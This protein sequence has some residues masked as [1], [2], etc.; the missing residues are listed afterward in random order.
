MDTLV[1]RLK[2]KKKQFSR[3]G[4]CFDIRLFSD[5]H[6][7]VPFTHSHQVSLIVMAA[8]LLCSLILWRIVLVCLTQCWVPN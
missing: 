1:T 4:I 8:A 7:L 3:E 2:D 6:D 5:I